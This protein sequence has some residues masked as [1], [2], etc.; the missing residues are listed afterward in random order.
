MGAHLGRVDED[1]G[2]LAGAIKL[3]ERAAVR[4]RIGELELGAIPAQP[5]IIT[6]IRVDRITAVKAMRQG[7][8]RPRDVIAGGVAAPDLPGATQ[9][10]LV[11]F[12]SSGQPLDGLGRRRSDGDKNKEKAGE[13]VHVK[14]RQLACI[15]LRFST[16]DPLI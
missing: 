1:F 12:P 3:E 2:L 13:R 16:P 8:G 15:G 14:S 4:I 10:A 11:I 5:L 9:R 7:D 6:N